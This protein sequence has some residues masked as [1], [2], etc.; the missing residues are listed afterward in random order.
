MIL[1]SNKKPDQLLFEKYVTSHLLEMKVGVNLLIARKG[2]EVG[3]SA[4]FRE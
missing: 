2:I 3:L 4:L 1:M